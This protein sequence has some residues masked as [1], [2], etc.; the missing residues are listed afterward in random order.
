MCG[1]YALY[2]PVSRLR[3]RFDVED[4]PDFAPR[5]NIA[6]TQ[7]VPV[8]APAPGGARGLTFARWG[9]IPSWV[10][11]PAKLHHPINA[12]AETLAEKPMFRNAFRHGRVLVPARGFYEWQQ[13]A[14]GKQPWF[15]GMADG[16]LFAF[17]GLAETWRGPQGELTTFTLITT[18]ANAL[19]AAIHDRMPLI[20]PARDYA[21]WLDPANAD[22]AGLLQPYAAQEM[23]AW[24]VGPT[25]NR[26]ANEGPAL[27]EPLPEP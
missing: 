23:R 18:P 6:P 13:R 11:D 14:G 12:K 17:G 24:P 26:A 21:S 15:I 1:R 2:G 5:Y 4:I 27:I 22:A 8:I 20:V 19:C 9:L 25:V 10:R 7:S 16:D 3:E